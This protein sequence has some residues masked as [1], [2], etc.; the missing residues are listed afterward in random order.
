MNAHC[1]LVL[2]KQFNI[3][4]DAR[5][6]GNYA[7]DNVEL[8]QCQYLQEMTAT[9]DFLVEGNFPTYEDWSKAHPEFSPSMARTFFVVELDKRQSMLSEL[10][11]RSLKAENKQR[12]LR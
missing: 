4:D 5:T 2:Q 3:S 12:E 6:I 8:H 10:R 11:S 1:A 7:A 9:P